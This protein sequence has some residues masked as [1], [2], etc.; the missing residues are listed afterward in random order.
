MF[1]RRNSS[2]RILKNTT[3]IILIYFVLTEFKVAWSQLVSYCVAINTA[4]LDWYSYQVLLLQQMKKTLLKYLYAFSEQN[5][6]VVVLC[7][8]LMMSV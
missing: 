1:Q 6:L 5:S 3:N 8:H 7:E 2:G 4:D